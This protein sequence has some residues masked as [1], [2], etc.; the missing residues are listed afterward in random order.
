MK[1]EAPVML[2]GTDFR[3]DPDSGKLETVPGMAQYGIAFDDFGRRFTQ[4][5]AD[6]IRQVPITDAA[7]FA[8]IPFPPEADGVVAMSDHGGAGPCYP[9]SPILPRFNDFDMAGRFTSACASFVYRGELLPPIYRGAVFVAE[10]VHNLVHVDVLKGDGPVSV[11]VRPEPNRDFLTSTDPW[12]RPCHF[13]HAPDG[14]LVICDM[15]RQHVE[16]P[17]WIPHSVLKRINVR[18]GDDRGRLWAVVPTGHRPIKPEDLAALSSEALIRRLDTRN[19]YIRDTIR[20]L[21]MTRVLERGDLAS[22]E[23]M[24]RTATLPEARIDAFRVLIPPM[25]QHVRERDHKP[26]P[27]TNKSDPPDIALAK[28]GLRDPDPMVRREVV[29]LIAS[30][31]WRPRIWSSL[32]PELARLASDPHPLVRFEVAL[33]GYELREVRTLR[34]PTFRRLAKDA[35]DPWM[36]AAMSS[37]IMDFDDIYCCPTD[38]DGGPSQAAWAREL[39]RTVLVRSPELADG[40]PPRVLWNR[41]DPGLLAAIVEGIADGHER[42]RK[43]VPLTPQ[44]ATWLNEFASSPSAELRAA[45]WRLAGF[46]SAANG[47]D[48]ALAKLRGEAGRIARDPK[49]PIDERARAIRVAV[50]GPVADLEP[51]LGTLLT[52]KTPPELQRTLLETALGRHGLAAWVGVKARWGSLGPDVRR[53]AIVAALSRRPLRVSVM[54]GIE[55]GMIEPTELDAGQRTGLLLDGDASLRER[56][57]KKLSAIKS[58]DRAAVVR[59]HLDVCRMKGNGPRGWQLFREH[60]G[61]CHRLE[62][63]GHGAG[64]NLATVRGNTR[65]RLL[66]SILNPSHSVEPAFLGWQVVTVDGEVITGVVRAESAASV[67]LRLADGKERTI[68]RG[69]IESM[70]STGKSLMPEGMERTVGRQGLADLIAFLKGE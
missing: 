45:A 2:T 40:V 34:L 67:T 48:A 11:G 5:N 32:G 24:A 41:R 16:H 37:A 51:L 57:A 17:E 29:R 13:T 44:L 54:E 1:L 70:K 36:R 39:V 42:I 26:T 60:C 19:G 23:R 35:T 49:A 15:H 31:M 38:E 22:L 10:P 4:T 66:E 53:G 65:E 61:G 62:N 46:T 7:A 18:A 12:F 25:P 3:L 8:R 63:A 28:F 20:R 55:S 21:L 14:A 6:H 9:T 52:P 68:N 50:S 27:P 43:P 47:D 69:D 58:E 59:D 30:Q 33:A 56:A 64:P